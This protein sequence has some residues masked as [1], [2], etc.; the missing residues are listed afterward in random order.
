[1]S[2]RDNAAWRLRDRIKHDAAYGVERYI[3]G[4]LGH[5]ELKWLQ[6]HKPWI[7]NAILDQLLRH[8]TIRVRRPR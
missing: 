1:M 7:I 8:Y 4:N 5:E 6:I 2:K 3:A